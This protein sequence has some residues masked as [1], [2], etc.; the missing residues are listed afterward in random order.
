MADGDSHADNGDVETFFA[1]AERASAEV[2]AAQVD[3]VIRHPVI[4]VVLESFCGFVLILNRQRQILVASPEFCQ[5]LAAYGVEEFVGLRPGE[6]LSCEHAWDGPGGCGTSLA[7]RHCGAVMAILAAHC[8]RVPVYDECWI[9]M[10]RKNKQESVEFRAKATPLVFSGTDIVV[11]T[12]HDISAEKRRNALEQTFL[13]D[14]RNILSGILNWCEVLQVERQDESTLSLQGLVLQ[15]RDLFSGHTL[16]VQA[17]NGELKVNKERLD[18]S[19][20]GRSLNGVFSHHPDSEGKSL[21]MRFPT[22]ATPPNT[23]RALVLRILNNMLANALEATRPGA[24]IVVNYA[25]PD[26]KPTFEVHNPG[27]IPAHIA[28]RIFQRSFSTKSGKG[29]GL[30]TYGM[31]L[32]AE[33]YLGGKIDFTSS[34]AEGTV[35]R[36]ILPAE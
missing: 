14:A 18:L 36:L 21:V 32:Y 24:T 10:R 4:K 27:L 3:Q 7:C 30:G 8:S 20:I 35:F 13:H 2:L 33:Q 17:E 9:S 1:P 6:A 29:H 12:L 26:G 22:C 34:E 16:L 28:T 11:L 15:L 5:A 23:D 19:S 31:R 25:T